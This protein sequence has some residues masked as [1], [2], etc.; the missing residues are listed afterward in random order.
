MERVKELMKDNAEAV[1]LR[2]GIRSGGCSGYE[3]DIS[4]AEGMKEYDEIV[5][6]DDVKVFIDGQAL[7]YVLGS[8]LDY[9]TD[10]ITAEFRF[11]NPNA[12]STCG[13]GISPELK[14]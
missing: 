6:V 14:S 2:V 7:L 1:G 8:E 13:C 9:F 12:T 11:S 5:E 10:R 4:M 3:Y